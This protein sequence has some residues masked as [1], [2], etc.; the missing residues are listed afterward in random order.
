MIPTPKDRHAEW[1]A[2]PIDSNPDDSPYLVSRAA[3]EDFPRIYDVVNEAFAKKR[4]RA[5]FDWLYLDNPTGIARCW[6]VTHRETGQLIKTGAGF[7]WPIWRDEA[8]LRGSVGGDAAT[9]PIW[10][11]K[12]LSA[13]RRTIRRTHPWADDFCSI[14]GPNAG[15]RAVMKNSGRDETLLG[16]LRAGVAV[17]RAGDILSKRGLGAAISRP[18]GR[19]IDAAFDFWRNLSLRTSTESPLHIERIDRFTADFDE[20]TLRCMSTKMYWCPHNADF[21][22]WRYLDHPGETYVGLAI[23]EKDVPIGY[24]VVL[25]DGKKATLSEFAVAVGSARASHALLRRALEVARE[26]GCQH[27]NFFATPAWRHWRLFY[28]AGFL[29][30]PSTNHFEA[31]CERYGQESMDQRNWQVMPGDRDYH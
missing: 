15:S 18:S 25:L 30:Y 26:A 28:R 6:I 17:L 1:L 29:P 10:Q 27:L 31:G 19:A 23:V 11:R 22:N 4:P 5:V 12:G 16:R 20:V 3:V 7:P 14:S 2:L 24:A 8:V 9:L 13:V 21:L